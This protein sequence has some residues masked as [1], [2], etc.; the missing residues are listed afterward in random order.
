M[1]NCTGLVPF[2]F[3]NL[4]PCNQLGFLRC[5]ICLLCSA[6]KAANLAPSVIFSP[7]GALSALFMLFGW[8]GY[9]GAF[10]PRKIAIASKTYDPTDHANV[11]IVALCS[12]TSSSLFF[13][14]GSN[15]RGF[16]RQN[17]SYATPYKSAF[18]SQTLLIISVNDLYLLKS[19]SSTLFPPWFSSRCSAVSPRLPRQNPR[20]SLPP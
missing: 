7:G 5:L 18:G 9:A 8:L 17:V 11:S 1:G 16:N 19:I 15:F 2:R 13:W 14:N 12:F 20:F 4:S 10:L 3:V 6:A